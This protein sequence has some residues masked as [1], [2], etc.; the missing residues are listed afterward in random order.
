MLLEIGLILD[1]VMERKLIVKRRPS[2]ADIA[3]R[4]EGEEYIG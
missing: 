4:L 1:G 2:N 3:L